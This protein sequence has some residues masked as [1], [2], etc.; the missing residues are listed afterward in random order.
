MKRNA[1]ETAEDSECRDRAQ[2][3]APVTGII[4]WILLLYVLG[5][6]LMVI[7]DLLNHVFI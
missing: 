5:Y 4:L 1:K 6:S 7:E 3:G 2:A